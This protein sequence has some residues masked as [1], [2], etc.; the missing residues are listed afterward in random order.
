MALNVE[1]LR[2]SLGQYYLAINSGYQWFDYQQNTIIPALEDLERRE[3]LR[4]AIFMPPGDSKSDIAT[5]T[6]VPW[7]LGRHPDHNAMVCSYSADLASD[8]FGA[9][10]KARMQSD[11][12][13]K[14]FP[15]SRLTQDSRSKTHFTTKMGGNFYSVGYSGGIGGKRLDCFPAGTMVTTD[16]GQI[17]IAALYNA[18]NKPK[19]LGF[20]HERGIVEWRAIR[21]TRR[22][23][24]H[25]L[26]EIR[27]TS[28]R[29]IVCTAD[30]R[31]YCRESGYRPAISLRPGDTL[32][33]TFVTPQQKLRNM[34]A[35]DTS[36]AK[37]PGMLSSDTPRGDSSRTGLRLLW[38]A[39]QKTPGRIREAAS[40]WCQILLLHTC[41]LHSALLG[42]ISSS[43]QLL[44]WTRTVGLEILF[45]GLPTSGAGCVETK[46]DM[47][48]MRTGVRPKRVADD[49]LLSLLCG[50]GSFFK[51]ER[52][53][54]FSFQDRNELRQT[55]RVNAPV[56][57]GTGR[58][59]LYRLSS[60]R[61]SDFG[62]MAR[63]TD[64]PNDSDYPSH[65]R[66]SDEQS[67]R[68]P[69]DDLQDM[70]CG[71][72]QIQGDSVAAV[73][74]LRTAKVPVY[75]IQVEGTNNFFANQVL[76][77]NCLIMDDLIKDWVDAE[78]ETIQNTLF[79]TYTGL[80]KDRLKPKAVIVM[81][82]HR[83]TQRDIYAR[84]LEHDGTVDQGG[85]WFVITLPAE[86]P[87][88][89]GKYLW[90]EYHG[91][92]HYEDFKK[93]EGKVWWAKFQQDPSASQAYKFKEEW[94]KFYDI[95]IPP[96][97][98]NTYMIVDPA[99]AKGKK[100]DYTSIHVWAA[101][102][103]KKLFLVDWIH[104]RLNPKERVE[105]IMRLTRQWKQQQTIYE[106]YGLLSDTYYLTEKMQEEGFD[107]RVYPVPV[108]RSGPR[109]NLSKDLRID[110]I[111]PFF[112]E[113]R[114]YL[115]RTC[116]RKI[117]DGRTVDLT[118][119]FIDEEC[120]LFKGVGSIA[121]EDD[122]DCMSRLLEPELVI[123]YMENEENIGRKKSTGG[124]KVVGGWEAVYALLVSIM[125][126]LSLWV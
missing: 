35:T 113:G 50:Q 33:A 126:L 7:Y 10:I 112:S 45:A 79:D 41:S 117:Y 59:S 73:R 26:V 109:H 6:F 23:L 102:Q 21:A 120:K 99:G 12:H 87:Q 38:D 121:H 31:I 116:M 48:S 101:G 97:R 118:K 11:L 89:P 123:T 13:L 36:G 25:D 83:W 3:I 19:V 28:N 5:R 61:G 56:D 124:Q 57:P 96:G 98:Y 65:R 81:C 92:K 115:P 16:Q 80:L 85:D 4:L 105:A 29:R 22:V 125:G 67:A 20:N 77:H 55:V 110:A 34:W 44:S 60:L 74:R 119:R 122:L 91:R 27:T 15:N 76:V 18:D 62:S 51:N 68:E 88:N 9:K 2:N 111:V 52:G 1:E 63:T 66:E 43:M 54:E 94:L 84:I 14:I 82:A 103:D 37:L 106:E 71:S 90:E 58:K 40:A 32:S 86:D 24:S 64:S 46:A 78:S 108:G 42:K 70:P 53:W 107:I 75:D 30:H 39:V 49:L 95:P 47:P 69:C 8:D 100:S 114:I 17:D 72:S 93:K 104:D